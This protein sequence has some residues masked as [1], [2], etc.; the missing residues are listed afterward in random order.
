VAG[1]NSGLITGCFADSQVTASAKAGGL[2][3]LNKE[4]TITDSYSAGNISG[5]WIIGGLAG[6]NYKG[7]ILR[8]Y[9][10][11]VPTGN[12]YIGGLVAAAVT[13]DGYQDSA[14]FWDEQVSQTGDS[15]MGKPKTT[16]QMQDTVTFLAAGWDFVNETENGRMQ[17]W[18]MLENDYPRLYW[19]ALAGDVNYDGAVDIQDLIAFVSEWLLMQQ[20][21]E[22]LQSD[23]NKD[24][25]VDLMDF[26]VIA[27]GWMNE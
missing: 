25:V 9:S 2:A 3:G 18:Y 11:A 17:L 4:G 15:A 22:R 14:N 23:I 6:E 16:A 19:Q 12:S 27:N 21:D 13:G 20:Q 1:E 8:C 7:K 24:A 10:A 26:D 5:N